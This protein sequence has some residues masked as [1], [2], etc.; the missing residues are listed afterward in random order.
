[1]AEEKNHAVK[2][3]FKGGAI[4]FLGIIIS[5]ISGLLYRILV[6]RYL[7][8]E[9]YGV[10]AVMMA[11]FS[12]AT[13]LAF[14][15]IPN[16]V[17]KYVSDY[18]AKGELDKARS[19]AR[20]GLDLVTVSS[21]FTA[22]FLFVLAPWISINIF[23]EPKAIW[24]I[25]MIAVIIPL[26]AYSHIFLS[27]TEAFEKMQYDVYTGR[28]WNSFAK[29]TLATALVYY[30][31]G[32]LG[33]AFA[34]AFAFGSAAFLSFYFANKVFPNFYRPSNGEREYSKLFHHSWPLF[35]SGL[36]GIVIGHIDTFAL[37]FFE[38]SRSVGLYQAAYPLA[39]VLVTG[40]TMFGS[41]FL[42]NASKLYAKD[43]LENLKSTYR[44][45]VK[46]IA[47]I[48][49]PVFVILFTFPRAALIVFGAE[50]FQVENVLRILAIG[51]ML[52]V[53]VGPVN[54]IYQAIERT[55][56]QLLTTVILAT[57]NGVLNI[58]LIPLY[59]VIGAAYASTLSFLAVF[60]V[61]LILVKRTMDIHPFRKSVFKILGAALISIAAVYILTNM[62]YT[63]TPTWFYI[64]NI[65]LFST[66]YGILVLVF[67]VIE[68]EDRMIIDTALQKTGLRDT[69]V[70]QLT[71]KII[72]RF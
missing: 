56:L 20:T 30:G 46:W 31:Y 5:K 60:I 61:N 66:I 53:L 54:R 6:G 17:Q 33:A 70:E 50:Y 38:G 36:F 32:Y 9:D 59:G 4:I 26:K 12:V 68:E 8:P 19:V 37:Q 23:S 13:T 27:V 2:S 1:M 22:V 44:V 71:D 41:I 49:L 47:L 25:R 51:F 45:V 21:I 58:A 10:I 63:H 15:G 72:E 55:N 40:T 39:M 34:Y 7:G 14:I 29:I 48:T 62:L 16:G 65:L 52:N 3:I 18:R 67:G 42:S 57:M 35:A 28:I 43:D 69:K 64:V 24:P 11:T